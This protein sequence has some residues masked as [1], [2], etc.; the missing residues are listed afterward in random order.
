MNAARTLAPL[1][2]ASLLLAACA[3]HPQTASR[4][5]GSGSDATVDATYVDAVNRAS[6]LSGVKVVWINPPRE[7]DRDD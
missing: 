1:A 5:A 2:L 7:V 4:P 3:S 6:R